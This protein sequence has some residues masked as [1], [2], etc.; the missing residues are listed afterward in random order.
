MGLKRNRNVTKLARVREARAAAHAP[1]EAGYCKKC[2]R[3][4]IVRAH[5]CLTCGARV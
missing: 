2:G 5:K 3:I 1:V 4:R